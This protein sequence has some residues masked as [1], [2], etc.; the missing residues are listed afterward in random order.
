[1]QKYQE[2]VIK[3]LYKLEKR[4]CK[5]QSFINSDDY[6]F[7]NESIDDQLLTSQLHSMWVYASILKR[8]VERFEAAVG[9]ETSEPV[10]RTTPK[11]EDL[12]KKIGVV[13]IED[14]DVEAAIEKIFNIVKKNVQEKKDGKST[15]ED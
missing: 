6:P 12:F 14:G 15:Q 13:K 8:R 7:S 5:L 3:E 9:P 2:R 11:D 10:S 4:A 1:M